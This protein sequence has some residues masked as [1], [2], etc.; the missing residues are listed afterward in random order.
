MAGGTPL[1]DADRWP[2]LDEVA[3]WIAD[4]RG[5]ASRAWW[6]APRSSGPTADRLRTADPDLRVVYLE[7]DRDT[8]ID[9]LEHRRG[10]F[11]P[12]AL[13]EG[14]LD[15]PRTPG[16]T[17]SPSSSE[18]DSRPPRRW[19]PSSRNSIGRIDRMS[20]RGVVFA[21]VYNFRDLGGYPPATDGRS[22]GTGSTARTTS[23]GCREGER[24]T[25]LALGIRTVVDLRRPHEIE[26]L[27]RIP[28]IE[29]WTYRH[30]HMPTRLAVAAL[31]R[32]HRTDPVRHR[33]LPRDEH[34]GGRRDR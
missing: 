14:Q 17:K 23:A 29:A 32:H 28:E 12:Q 26:E 19:P 13:L 7:T 2:W 16:R 6:G 10:H 20:E 3:A 27:G 22:P 30:V 4:R 11:F 1:T 9:R 21:D 33:A 18:V 5:R 25:I 15:G 31:R 34:R 24:K 8:L